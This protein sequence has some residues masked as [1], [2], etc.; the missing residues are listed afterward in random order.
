MART[1]D[2]IDTPHTT[3]TEPRRDERLEGDR[4]SAQSTP[5][6]N[7]GTTTEIEERG[8]GHRMTE[9]PTT[10]HGTDGRTAG[11]R[12]HDA[13]SRPAAT[14]SAAP[15]RPGRAG[16]RATP[17]E[18]GAIHAFSEEQ[19]RDY[20]ERWDSIQAS[21]IDQPRESVREAERLVGEMT[22]RLVEWFRDQH[23]GLE[24]RWDRGDEVSTEDLRQALRSYRSFFG[25]LL[26]L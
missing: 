10:A 1:T 16:E 22:D 4:A 13:A 21:F 12:L 25:R 7:L 26:H 24:S 15:A 8:T 23:Q 14:S 5:R 20:H 9:G 3:E 18:T 17:E 19:S 2:T 11:E 6:P